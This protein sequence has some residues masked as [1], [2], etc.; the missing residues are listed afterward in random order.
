MFIFYIVLIFTMLFIFFLKI[1]AMLL[2]E[3]TSLFREEITSYECGFEFKSR[4][5]LP[6]SFRYYLLTLIFL[7]FDLELVFLV[8]LPISFFF[9]FSVSS[10]LVL[11][12]F[13]S[14]LILGLIY[15]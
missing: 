15:E 13:L 7:L 11:L 1:A 8:F 4:A 5:R 12:F 9:S 6:F 2:S 14:V 3:K 10:L